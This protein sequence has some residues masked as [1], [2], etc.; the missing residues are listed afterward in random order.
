VT[1]AASQV[2]RAG[3]KPGSIRAR[4]SAAGLLGIALGAANSLSNSL[5]SAYSP[6]GLSPDGIL[7]LQILAA[8]LGTTWAWAV[9][10]F[11]A[12]WIAGRIWAGPLAGVVALLIA[13]GTYYWADKVSGYSGGFDGQG[14]LYWGLLAIPC[15]LGMGLLGS[16][17]S[18]PR[19][20]SLA[21][22]LAAPAAIMILASPTGTADIQPWP[23]VVTYALAA[24]AGALIVGVWVYRVLLRPPVGPFT[25]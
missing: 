9:T 7:P 13:D 2:S 20:W 6:V 15:G 1:T 8:V 16:L 25:A 19:W 11:V 21:P 10:A 17:A 14:M 4:F 5:G 24:I 18:Q 3:F 22:G 12:G 23:S